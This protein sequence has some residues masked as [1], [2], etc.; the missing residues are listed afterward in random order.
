MQFSSILPIDRRLWGAII[1][2]QSGP[3]NDGNKEVIRIPQSCN[4]IAASPSD[5]LVSY[6][7]HLLKKSY[8]FVDMHTV[9]S[10]L[11][12]DWDILSNT[13]N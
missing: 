8:H 7:R 4:I 5:Y 10:A 2:G 3:R 13:N 1:P 9:Y 11:P 12:A 6:T